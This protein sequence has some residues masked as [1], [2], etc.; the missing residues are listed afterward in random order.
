MDLTII[1]PTFN[2]GKNIPLLLDKVKEVADDLGCIYEIIVVDI[3]SSDNTLQV[4]R[5]KGAVAFI[6]QDPGYGGALKDAFRV[7]KGKYIITMDADFSHNPYI[8]KR[9][10]F[11]R[12]VAHVVVASRYT[13]GGLADMPLSRRIFS[14]SLNKFFSFS[15]S[16]PLKDI[17]SGFRLYNAEI[18]NEVDFSEKDFNVLAEI[19]IKAYMHGYRVKE[20]PFHY[21]PRLKGKS[22][23]KVIKFGFEFFITLLKL[24]KIRNSTFAADYDERA[25]YSRIPIQRFWQR[26]RYGIIVGFAGYQRRVLDAGCGSSKILSALPQ[27]IGMDV[28]FKKLRYNLSFGNPLIRSDIRSIAFKDASF[29]EVICSEVIEHLE[30]NDSVFQELSRILRKGGILILGTPDYSRW[31]W[32]VIEWL[33][34]KC[35]PGGYADE[36]ITHYTKEEL[37]QK[38]QALGFKLEDYRYILGSELICKFVKVD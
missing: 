4:A 22:H 26:K 31:S 35:A 21:S 37:I 32:I 7:A 9:L 11:Y 14:I 5:D 12:D 36:H 20:I 2:E 18:F 33:Y 6:Q 38:M 8:I 28:S 27:A 25:F 24:W 1:I 34:K 30:R 16:L 10:Y 23:A 15:L 29:D 3:G 13:R 17:S 19:L